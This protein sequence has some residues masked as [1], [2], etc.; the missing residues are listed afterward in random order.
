[1]VY[2]KGILELL[3]GSDSYINTSDYIHLGDKISYWV[4]EKVVKA[5]LTIEGIVEEMS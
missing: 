4:V 5:T 3:N 2:S 1:M